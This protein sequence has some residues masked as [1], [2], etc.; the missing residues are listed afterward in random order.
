MSQNVDIRAFFRDS[1]IGIWKICSC[2]L[3]CVF[4]VK[5]EKFDLFAVLSII[6]MHERYLRSQTDLSLQQ[7]RQEERRAE[8]TEDIHQTMYGF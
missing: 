8:T 3:V 5:F 6:V 1:C 2:E 7:K 4:V